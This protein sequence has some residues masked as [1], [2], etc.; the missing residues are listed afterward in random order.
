M[1]RVSVVIPTCNRPDLLPRAIRSVLAQTFQDFEI[2]V[3]DDGDK[4]RAEDTVRSF[5]DSRMRYLKNDPPKRGGS[6]T[7]NI[8]INAA[9]GEYVAFLDDDDEWMSEKLSVQMRALEASFPGV[10]FVYCAVVNV[11]ETGEVRTHVPRGVRDLREI[12]LTRF[13]GILTSGLVAKKNALIEVGMFDE[14]LPSS[15][16]AELMIRLAWKYGGVGIDD[17]L[18]RMN[19]LPRE[20]INSDIGRKIRGRELVLEKHNALYACYPSKLAKHYFWMGL[21]CRDAG[22]YEKARGFFLKAF[23]IAGNPR[24][25]F[26]AFVCSLRL[27]AVE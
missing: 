21:W 11:S 19:M 25:L 10:A 14:S 26:H 22:N 9:K 2:I 6:A 4:E 12:V 1:P 13:K 18:V 5:S 27:R 16:E 20:H 7:R 23:R 8:G 17:P 3:I 24:Y 15:Q